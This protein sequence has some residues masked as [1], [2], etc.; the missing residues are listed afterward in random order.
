MSV[1]ALEFMQRYMG[2]LDTSIKN[3][4]TNSLDE[5]QKAPTILSNNVFASETTTTFTGIPTSGTNK[6]TI[7]SSIAGVGI[8]DIDDSTSGT[9]TITFEAQSEPMTIYLIIEEY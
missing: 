3:Y 4:V 8:T 9:V 1:I 7:C 6:I 5:A 2:N